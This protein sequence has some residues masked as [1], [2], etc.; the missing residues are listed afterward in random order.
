MFTCVF[1][2]KTMNRMQ[3]RLR[4]VFFKQVALAIVIAA[5]VAVV[6]TGRPS[7]AT[8]IALAGP[9]AHDDTAHAHV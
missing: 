4:L 6:P 9:G 7:P 3:R 2:S 1:G 5:G 8:P